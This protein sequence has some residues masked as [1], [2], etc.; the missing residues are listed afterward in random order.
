M[1]Q[2]EVQKLENILRRHKQIFAS[3]PGI[4]RTTQCKLIVKE[5]Q[6][7]FVKPYPIPQSKREAVNE[8]IQRML[9]L[10]VTE[11]SDSPYNSPLF[12]VEKKNGEFRVVLD[13][14]PVNKFFSK[15]EMLSGYWQVPLHPDS[16]KF[17]AFLH[18]GRSYQYRVLPFG[19]NISTSAFV[20][21]MDTV[22]GEKLLKK[23]TTCV[24]DIFIATATWDEHINV[25]NEVL[26]AFERAGI[27]ANLGKSE[28]GKKEI[29]FLGH[30]INDQGIL[31]E[32]D[33]LQA[34]KDF[35]TPRC[36]KQLRGF[37]GLCGWHRK[38]VNGH[39]LSNPHL[40]NLLKNKAAW[41][42]TEDCQKAFDALKEQLCNAKLLSHPDFSKEFFM[43]CDSSDY[44]LGV[45]LYQMID[46]DV[47][48][49]VEHSTNGSIQQMGETVYHYRKRSISC[50]VGF[51][52][53][54][55]LFGRQKNQCNHRSY[56]IVNCTIAD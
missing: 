18:C 10:G 8:E 34:I 2:V 5:H 15:I 53:I 35:P 31:P 48:T 24:D 41:N 25:L 39:S 51:S 27:T 40:L 42:W 12:V 4:I 16:R 22:L 33:K 52:E 32:E 49:I 45:H 37:L 14:R 30:V 26:S 46:D 17:T 13:A 50:A 36:K 21:A 55:L 9:R 11:R 54:S 20:R 6:P 44:G 38:F 56:W 28:F 19:L 29:S 3:E 1:E 43:A 47:K 7:F 23:V